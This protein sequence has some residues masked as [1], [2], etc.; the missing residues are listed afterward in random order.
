MKQI[1]VTDEWLCKYMPIVGEA[2]IRELEEGTDY[3]YR[4]SAE[5]EAHA[6]EGGA[7]MDPRCLQTAQTYSGPEHLCGCRPADIDDER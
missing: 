7:S 6:L 4:F 3:G 1:E 2:I 5:D